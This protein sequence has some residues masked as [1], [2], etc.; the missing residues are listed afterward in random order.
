[1]TRP[2]LRNWAGNVTFEAHAVHRPSSV[3]QLQALVA[4]SSR[5]RALGTGHSFNHVADTDGDL[6]S[7]VAMP[8]TVELD[9][10]AGTV[11]VGAGV[12]YAELTTALE[13]RGW[14]L[15]N[16]GSLPHISVGGATATG[17]HGSGNALGNLSTAVRAVE[18][19]TA[20][21][22]RATVSRDAPEFFGAVLAL[23]SL[24]VVVSLTLDLEPS[25]VVRQYVYED[26]PPEQLDET[27]FAAAYSVSVFTMWG[28][29]PVRQV[30]LKCRD[31]GGADGLGSGAREGGACE[32]GVREGGAPEVGATVWRGA[33][34]AGGPRH[35][36]PGMPAGN[37]TAQL[38][39][40]GPW[41]ERLPH[42]RHDY[43]PSAGAEIQSEYLVAR[44]DTAAALA[45]VGSVR[46]RFIPLLQSSE[47]RTVAA[48]DLW[49]SPGYRRDCLA[50]HFTWVKDTPAVLALLPILEDVLA[51][52][53]PRP[54]WAKPFTID[55]DVI[56]ARYP[57]LPEAER[58]FRDYDPSGKFRNEM[59]DRY[60]PGG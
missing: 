48:D 27:L 4:G 45:A 46:E 38:G 37:C 40:P 35:P 8:R 53:E 57:R 13:A 44:A 9:D 16:L 25:F 56:R 32:G 26:L 2:R 43:R 17:T 3:A 10:V 51:P 24:G 22:E 36:T 42:F 23:G 18:L 60:L 12:R 58:L 1:M 6:V 19:V 39:A 28:N 15:P 5:L 49:L 50:I 7:L 54:H 47:L 14:A 34:L 11:R 29:G 52:F 33:R 21:G 30:W 41:H 59:I 20:T 31:R 55:P